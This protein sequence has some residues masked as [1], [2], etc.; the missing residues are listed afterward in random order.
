MMATATLFQVP[1]YCF[2]TNLGGIKYHW[3][4]IKP[5]ATPANL[6][7]PEIVEED[8]VT[9]MHTPHHFELLYW[10]R[11]HFDCIVSPPDT[12]VTLYIFSCSVWNLTQLGAS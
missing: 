7:V 4:A 3:E 10:E 1:V 5:I 11:T 6:R 12:R 2:Y 9:N 8:P